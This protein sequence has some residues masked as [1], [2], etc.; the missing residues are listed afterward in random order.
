MSKQIRKW[1][2]EKKNELKEQSLIESE[3]LMQTQ[4]Q[5]TQ[6]EPQQ[7]INQEANRFMKLVKQL[8]VKFGEKSTVRYTP[9]I[10]YVSR[11]PKMLELLEELLEKSSQLQSSIGKKVFGN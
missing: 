8:S 10:R 3:N 9:L 11:N 1:I 6:Q 5:Q 2:K 4:P 7:N